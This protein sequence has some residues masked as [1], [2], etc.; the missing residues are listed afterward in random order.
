MKR[1]FKFNRVLVIGCCG[2]GKTT[3]S[4][5][6]K[7]IL[8]LPVIHLDAHYH[9]PKWKEPTKEDWLNTLHKLTRK[10][11]W[12]MDG[13][14][15]DFL[16]V[17][18]PRSDAIIFLDYNSIKCFLRVIKRNIVDYGKKRSDMAAGCK[19][20]FDI[21]FLKYVLMYNYQ[22]RKQIYKKLYSVKSEKEIV[23]LKNDYEVDLFLS[24][25]K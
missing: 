14:Y 7:N 13:T 5:K 6:L 23:I 24:Q 15:L 22:N 19:E 1:N 17:R 25:I 3:L 21:V 10:E 12:I 18:I 16:D 8:N 9:K 20:N 11:K 2:A 4:K